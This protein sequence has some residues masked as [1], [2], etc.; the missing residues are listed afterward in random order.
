[1]SAQTTYKFATKVNVAG[2]IADIAPYAIDSFQNEEENGVMQF[3]IGVVHGSK[4]GVFVKKPA[5]GATAAKFVGITTNNRTTEL[6]LDGNSR[7]VKG[8]A[9]GVM[10]YGR[11]YAKVKTGK[12]PKF[13]DKVYMV[14]SGDETGYFSNAS[15]DGVAVAGR[16]MGGVDGTN[17]IAEIELFNAPQPAAT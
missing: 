15:G 14:V 1:M 17:M 3:G 12:T 5:S 7:I 8:A 10:A 16:F 6:D 11:I 4:E 9:V 2:G 13:G